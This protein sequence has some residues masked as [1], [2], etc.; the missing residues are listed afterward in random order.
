[1]WKPK[2]HMG[3]FGGEGVS[4]CGLFEIIITHSVLFRKFSTGVCE[5]K[6]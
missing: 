5:E 1:M 4:P 3:V 2:K 6:N